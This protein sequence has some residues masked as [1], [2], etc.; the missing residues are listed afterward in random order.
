MKSQNEDHPKR[1]AVIRI[2]GRVNVRGDIEDTMKMLR[3]HRVNHCALVS[4]TPTLKGMIL[5]A[6]DYITWGDV[7]EK[8]VSLLLKNR[9]EL[10]GGE[11]LTDTYVKKN[12][13][14]KSIADFAK[15]FV[16]SK[17]ELSDVPDLKP[18]FR[19]H[20]PRK[21][22]KRIKRTFGASGALGNRGAQIKDLIYKM[23]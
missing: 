10:V 22:H 8:D 15:A 7:D 12:T 3:L 9:G 2:R 11:R 16:A 18:I 17:A 13:G 14:F 6:K 5:K 4:D 1:L 19:L 20:P 21:G 23:R